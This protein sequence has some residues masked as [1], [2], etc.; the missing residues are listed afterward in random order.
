MASIHDGRL[1]DVEV[2][3]VSL[4]QM[5]EPNAE[6]GFAIEMTDDPPWRLNMDAGNYITCEGDLPS[7]PLPNPY[8]VSDFESPQKLCA[9]QFSGGL[10]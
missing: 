7:F 6:N 1:G 4:K 9:V 10:S 5:I 8:P 2:E 3:T